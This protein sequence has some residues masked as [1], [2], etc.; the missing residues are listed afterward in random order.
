MQKQPLGKLEKKGLREVWVSEAGDFT[1][2]L[3][4]DEN[5]ALLG[6]VLDLDLELESQEK[7]VGPFRAD[8]LCKDLNTQQ[9]VLIEN[10]IEKTDHNHLGQLLTY[11]AGLKAITIVWVASEFTDEHRAALDWL[12]EVTEDGINFFGLEIELWQ[13]GE[14]PFAPRFNVV[15]KPNL[16]THSISEAARAIEAGN[17]SET[18][19]LQLEYWT[20]FRKFLQARK[21]IVRSQKP[22]PQHWMNF[23]LGRSNTYLIGFVNTKE[24]RIGISVI[25]AGTDAKAF[26]HLLEGEKD[27]IE[28]ELGQELVWRELPTKTESHIL[29]HHLDSDPFDHSRWNEYQTWM[30]ESL[31]KFSHVFGPR[32]KRLNPG[33]YVPNKEKPVEENE[34]VR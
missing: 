31:E 24:K 6:E 20:E 14:S 2:W 7:N 18:R 22:F 21:S 5:L 4:Q 1:P 25:L 12:N 15:S 10:Q 34:I 11:A 16:W 26:F 8:I 28:M 3:A 29:L 9:W 19:K 27:I 23:A 17:L 13:I 30:A 33:D 32:V